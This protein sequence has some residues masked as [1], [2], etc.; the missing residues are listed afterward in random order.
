M[1]LTKNKLL[2][3]GATGYT[4]RLICERAKELGLNF[5]IA[6]RRE[7]PLKEL[8]VEL[9]TTYEVFLVEDNS[10]WKNALKDV[11]CL[12]NA[13]GPFKETASL[14]MNACIENKVHYLDIS[15]ELDSY[16]LAGRLDNVARENNIML[17]S[18]GGMFVSYDALALHTALRADKPVKLSVAFR[19][20]GGFSRGSI[21]SSKNI[22]DLGVLVRKNGEIIQANDPQPKNFDFGEGEEECLPTPLGGIILSY[23][24]TGIKDIEEYFQILLLIF[25]K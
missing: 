24:S 25:G 6:G 11:Y 12:I 7:E 22:V 4:G 10:G 14:A 2:I 18:G 21:K 19:H 9:D 23:K 16:Q 15:A 3:Y 20:F 5:S 8:A 1:N 17:L 13:A